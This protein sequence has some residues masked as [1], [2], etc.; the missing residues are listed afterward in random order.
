[1]VKEIDKKVTNKIR[2]KLSIN[3]NLISND[4]VLKIIKET[5]IKENKNFSFENKKLA[6]LTKIIFSRL[7]KE[8]SILDEYIKNENI[9]EI[10]VI[11]PEN[12][13]IEENGNLKKLDIYFENRDELNEIVR[14]IA[15]KIHRE[16]N[17][18]NPIL[19]ARLEDGSRV[20]AV[21]ENI[22]LKGT[23][24]TIRKFPKKRITMNDLLEKGTITIEVSGFLQELVKSAK[25][26]FISGGTSSGKT[27]FLNILSSYIPKHERVITIE[28][29]AEL[30]INGIA[31]LV[32]LEVR[33]SND[34]DK[35]IRM[36]DLIKTSLRMRPDRII[37]GEVRGEEV[38]DMIQAMNTGHDGSL[39]TGHAN[40][41]KAMLYRLEAMFLQG[42][43]Y[44][45]EAIRAQISE[46]IDYIV[47][48][49]RLTDGRRVVMEISKVL[50]VS[51]G[52]IGLKKIFEFNDKEGLKKI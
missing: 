1:V 21:Y 29:S 28:D 19:D 6:A 48:L 38:I 20:N 46:G 36:K 41:A 52:E 25:N 49:A 31:N 15:G 4:E 35:Q 12:I 33:N 16:I 8:L 26:I 14:R 32:S 40:S 39:S 10:M 7:R 34:A 9:S 51:N 13:F 42:A 45:I 22:S 17:E 5:V 18:R 23:A 30:Q 50:G 3:K 11:G 37:V 24:L 2:K 43:A 47:H 44:P 27:T